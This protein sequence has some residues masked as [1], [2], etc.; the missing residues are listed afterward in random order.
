MTVTALY[1]DITSKG[2]DQATLVQFL[3]NVRDQVN[4]LVA[5]ANQLRKNALYN[6]FGNPGF[7]ISTNFDVKNGTAVFYTNGGTLKT[8]AAN[9]N[10]DTGTTKTITT[11]KWSAAALSVDASGNGVVTWAPLGTYATEAAAIAAIP[12]V[13]ATETAI[14]YVTV[15]AAGSTWTAGTDALASGTGGTPATTTNYY[16]SINANATQ[17]GAAVTSTSL[18]LNKG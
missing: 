2:L 5:Q 6:V 12:V 3:G 1:A 7:V 14:G 10:F 4:E 11:A 18:T 8:L 13:A 15:L 17:I 9:A 16:N